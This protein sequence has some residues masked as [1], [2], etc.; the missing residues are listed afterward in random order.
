MSNNALKQKV[1]MLREQ[2]AINMKMALMKVPES[3]QMDK[4]DP[5]FA[6]FYSR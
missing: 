3:W 5:G 4:N 6:S 2:A 1:D